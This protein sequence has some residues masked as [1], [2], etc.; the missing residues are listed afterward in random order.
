MKL[1]S[2]FSVRFQLLIHPVGLSFLSFKFWPLSLLNGMFL[3]VLPY[4]VS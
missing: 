4:G 1:K 2:C 3:L